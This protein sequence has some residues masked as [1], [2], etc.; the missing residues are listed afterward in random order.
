MDIETLGNLGEFIG[1]IAVLVTLVYIALQSR[2]SVKMARQ[3]SHS[4][5]LTRRQD[6]MML[7]TNDRDF[8]EV[9][10]KGCSMQQ[11][12]AIDAQRFT[13]FGMSMSS[14]VQDA[15]IQFKAGLINEDVWEAERAILAVCLSQPG[16][17]DWWEHGQ[18]YLTPEFS[19][20]MD[21]L[22]TPNLV[23]YDPET[24]SWGRPDGGRF[25]RDA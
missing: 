7:L 11:M 1:S 8:I 3:H 21:N 25:G 20:L 22:E 9:F 10:A 16:F 17:R 15:Y 18:Q 6:L 24:K 2:Q 5:M 23:L 12:D 19:H 4:D 14:H 13:S